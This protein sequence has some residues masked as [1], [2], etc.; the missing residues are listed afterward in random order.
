MGLVSS[1]RVAS[2]IALDPGIPGSAS[3]IYFQSKIG[4]TK[5]LQVS[6]KN[7]LSEGET[8]CR[9]HA[10]VHETSHCSNAGCRCQDCS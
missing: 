5:F 10:S 1:I 8:K 7:Y 9:H 2:L 3:C 6:G 4:T